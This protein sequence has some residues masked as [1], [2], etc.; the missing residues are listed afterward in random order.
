MKP[1]A[2]TTNFVVEP[3]DRAI[4]AHPD[5]ISLLMMIFCANSLRHG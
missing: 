4:L 2:L 3:A 1:G 5:F